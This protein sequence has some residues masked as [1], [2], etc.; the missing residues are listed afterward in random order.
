M[1]FE[2][3][4]ERSRGIVQ[5]A[6]THAM[7]EG[8]QQLTPEHLLKVLLDDKEGLAAGLIR[9][10]GGDPTAALKGAK[11]RWRPYRKSTAPARGRSI[12][13]VNWSVSSSR[14]RNS[15][16]RRETDSSLWNACCLRSRCSRARAL[17]RR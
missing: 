1:N 11:L 10:A 2:N 14:Q 12:R 15:R 3:Y 4:T 17:R 8:H 16:T 6:Q 5:S 13:R 9:E 7:R